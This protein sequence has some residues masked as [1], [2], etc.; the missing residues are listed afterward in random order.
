[1][2]N[3]YTLVILIIVHMFLVYNV[4]EQGKKYYE[5][6]IKK[7]KITPKVYDIGMKYIPDLSQ[8]RALEYIINGIAL[9]LPFVFGSKVLIPYIQLSIY[10]YLI[11]H[12]FNM[13]TILPKHK[14]C[15]DEK[16]DWGNYIFG[17]CY[18]KIFSGHFA[19]VLLVFLIAQDTNLLKN[20]WISYILLVL[21]GISLVAVRY[22]YTVDIAVSIVVTLLLYNTLKEQ[23]WT[24]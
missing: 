3:I 2:I 1:M 16:F 6:R 18:D 10:M 14:K 5:N 4:H 13:L 20:T 24:P 9:T 22:H 8:N 19:S 7:G 12:I 23:V 11:R 21:Y 15:N 17:H